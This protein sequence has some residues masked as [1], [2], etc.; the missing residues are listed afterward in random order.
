MP[1]KIIFVCSGNTCRSPMAQALA[2]RIL[3]DLPGALAAMVAVSSAGIMAADGGPSANAVAVMAERGIDISGHR[4]K[5]LSREDILSAGLVLTMT[6]RHKEAV[7]ASALEA[8]AKVFTL[9]EYAGKQVHVED[10]YLQPL[11]VYRRCA[12]TLEYLVA[13]CLKRLFEDT[14]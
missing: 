13:L 2:R 7:L 8:R 6:V 3:A 9:G 1:V 12:G 14:L 4:A 10:P 5:N 11:D